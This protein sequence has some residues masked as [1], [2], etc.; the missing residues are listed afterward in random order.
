MSFAFVTVE[1][2]CPG[3][4]VVAFD[5]GDGLNAMSMQLA[6]ELTAT[7]NQLYDDLETHAIVL[8]GRGKG[9]FGGDDQLL[10]LNEASI[11]QELFIFSEARIELISFNQPGHGF[12]LRTYVS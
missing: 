1:R 2:P 7:A 10:F 9:F 12:D 6:R 11:C 3:V 8:V 5:R 4:A